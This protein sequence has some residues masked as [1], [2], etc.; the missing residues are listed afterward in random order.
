MYAAGMEMLYR[1][2][3]E[4]FVRGEKPDHVAAI[5]KVESQLDNKAC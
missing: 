2:M 1:K 5:D 3:W 4:R